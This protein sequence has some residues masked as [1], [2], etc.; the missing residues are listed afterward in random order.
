MKLSF[1]D[2]IITPD[3]YLGPWNSQP[4]YS[5]GNTPQPPSLTP[6]NSSSRSQEIKPDDD[7]IHQKLLR[8]AAEGHSREGIQS[9]LDR[10]ADCNTRD[11]QDLTPLHHAAYNGHART[12][13]ALIEAHANSNAQHYV[14]GT[15]LCLAAAKGYADIVRS[16]FDSGATIHGTAGYL[17]S[18]MHCACLS[19]SVDVI[20]QVIAH[21]GLLTAQRTSCV[22]IWTNMRDLDGTLLERM[23]VLDRKRTYVFAFSSPVLVAVLSDHPSSLARC[24]ELGISKD[25]RTKEWRDTP[26]QQSLPILPLPYTVFRSTG[27]TLLSWAS[28]YCRATAA[29]ALIEAGA[30]IEAC[31][32]QGENA[33]HHVA[34]MIC[35]DRKCAMLNLVG[36]LATPWTMQQRDK[37]GRCALHVAAALKNVIVAER[38]IEAGSPVDITIQSPDIENGRTALH[39]AA[40]TGDLEMAA[41]L[42]NKRSKASVRDAH[43][44]LACDLARDKGHKSVESFILGAM[45]GQQSS[46]VLSRQNN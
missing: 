23:P 33:L 21:G 30:D 31:N 2:W 18:V 35:G 10:G 42:I 20:D 1:V 44:W 25:E 26:P 12:V 6:R 7:P 39:T 29:K 9:L 5:R 28:V 40:V 11:S 34:I 13:V 43:G 16:L 36:F 4:E 41:L 46:S 22:R 45:R 38:L 19:G 15:P 8:A 32:N 17:G 24:L 3:Y 27:D 37:K 14:Y